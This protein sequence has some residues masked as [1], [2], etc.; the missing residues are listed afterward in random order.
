MHDIGYQMSGVS[1][2]L[3]L[4]LLL[5]FRD[6]TEVYSGLKPLLA[7]HVPHLSMGIASGDCLSPLVGGPERAYELTGKWEG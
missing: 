5:L 6:P 2:S 7:L 3:L 1:L 4:L